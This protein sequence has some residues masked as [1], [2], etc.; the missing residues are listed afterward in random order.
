MSGDVLLNMLPV[1]SVCIS[2][3]GYGILYIV[4]Y[5]RLQLNLIRSAV[6]G[7]YSVA[8]AGHVLP[9]A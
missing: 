1:L 3:C 5:A 2:L 7:R 6:D 8:L 4:C 9:G